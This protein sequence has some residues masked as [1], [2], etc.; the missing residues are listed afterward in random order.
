MTSHQCSR[1]QN[2]QTILHSSATNLRTTFPNTYMALHAHETICHPW[3]GQKLKRKASTFANSTGDDDE[4]IY[5]RL[6][7]EQDLASLNISSTQASPH[8][9]V[10]ASS[11]DAMPIDDINNTLPLLPTSVEEPSMAG[12][13]DNDQDIP[14]KSFSSYEPEKDREDYLLVALVCVTDYC[15]AWSLLTLTRTRKRQRMSLHLI[16]YHLLYSNVSKRSKPF[17]PLVLPKEIRQRHWC[18]L[19]LYPSPHPARNTSL[20][21]TIHPQAKTRL[22][23]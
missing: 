11:S 18:Y 7:L 2:F 10:D 13:Q 8:S 23:Y 1:F 12:P 19:G 16:S 20:A 5:K 9:A 6:R 4:H 22:R 3:F 21:R 15:Q 14:M 17:R